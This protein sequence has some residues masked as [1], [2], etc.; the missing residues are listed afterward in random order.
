MTQEITDQDRIDCDPFFG[1]EGEL[2]CRKV[3]IKTARKQHACF[4]GSAFG[5]DNHTIQPGDRYRH[6]KALVDGDFWG[7]WKCCMKCID[8]DIRG[9][10]EDEGP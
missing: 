5:G 1:D 7:E 10:Y 9:D 4:L 2:K 8:R 3:T 6:E